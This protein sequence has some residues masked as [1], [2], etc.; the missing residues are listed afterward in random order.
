MQRV[1]PTLSQGRAK[2]RG[3]K[4]TAA[5]VDAETFSLQRF[6][7][8]LAEGQTLALEMVFAP[9]AAM[10]APPDPLWREVQALAPRLLTRSAAAFV[11]YCQGQASKY[12]LKGGRIAAAR[13]AERYLA[14]AVARLGGAARLAAARAD[15]EALVAEAA[16]REPGGQDGRGERDGPGGLLRLVEMVQPN[17]ETLAFFEICGKRVAFTASLQEAWGLSRR[18][19]EDYGQRALAAERSAGMDW[20]ALSH[21][22]RIG[23]EALELFAQ[24]RICFPRPEAAHLLAIRRG[25]IPYAEI[26]AEI[27]ALVGAVEAAAARSGLPER[28]DPEVID[29]L[30]ARVYYQRVLAAGAP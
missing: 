10:L 26:A 3:E 20:K 30:V 16:A 14:E 13:R 8:L 23:Q 18:I 2:A 22:V 29:G 25:E 12:G 27:E 6:L 1:A 28:A 17:G 21:A 24:G 9:D 4:N 19:L 11:R 15:L 7:E 5:D